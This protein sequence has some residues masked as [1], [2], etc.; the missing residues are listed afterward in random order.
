ML[1]KRLSPYKI[2]MTTHEAVVWWEHP[3]FHRVSE[4]IQG[5][6]AAAHPTIRYAM[7]ED[8]NII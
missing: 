5:T 7:I 8:V 1:K 3:L 4:P 6:Q 2:F